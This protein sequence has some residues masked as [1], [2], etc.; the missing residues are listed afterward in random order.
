[1]RI[2]KTKIDQKSNTIIFWLDGR[3]YPLESIYNTAYVFSD[4]A[5]VHMEGDP[6]K[7]M[8][9]HLRGKENLNNKKLEALKGEFLNE[10]LNFLLRVQIA[11]RNKKIREFIVGSALVYGAEG[12]FLFP[13]AEKGDQSGDWRKDPLGI[14]VPWE[15]KS[16]KGKQPKKKKN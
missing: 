8:K 2:P 14:A 13:G 3:V 11:K 7:E 5:F 10:L 12:G 4:R 1:M 6:K 9:I 16:A 15:E